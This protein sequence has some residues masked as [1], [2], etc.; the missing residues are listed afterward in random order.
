[1]AYWIPLE[2]GHLVASCSVMDDFS[3]EAYI[4]IEDV[5]TSNIIV[6]VALDSHF[7]SFTVSAPC[8][9]DCFIG[10]CLHNGDL[11]FFKLSDLLA[12]N[13]E[14]FFSTPSLRSESVV[15][16]TPYEGGRAI[17]VDQNI[18]SIWDLSKTSSME[19]T[20][21]EVTIPGTCTAISFNQNP[22]VNRIAALACVDPQSHKNL[23]CVF[24]LSKNQ[25]IMKLDLGSSA[26][27]TL[28]W[29]PEITTL[30]AVGFAGDSPSV[31]LWSMRNRTAPIAVQEL[32]YAVS[33]VAWFPQ[34]YRFIAAGDVGGNVR[35]LYTNQQ[36]LSDCGLAA[37]LE[38]NTD[39]TRVTSL[40][41]SP[42]LSGAA[43][44]GSE[45]KFYTTAC[46][47]AKNMTVIP[48]WIA[49]N[50]G[51][52]DCNVA[53]D[54]AMSVSVQG[55]VA[56]FARHWLPLSS[57]SVSD[58]DSLLRLFKESNVN[59]V[60]QLVGDS[61]VTDFLKELTKSS[62]KEALLKVF[63]FVKDAEEEVETTEDTSPMAI[64]DDAD[65]FENLSVKSVES[66]EIEQENLSTEISLEVKQEFIKFL[67]LGD[68]ESAYEL[69]VDNGF[70][71]KAS[72][73][74]MNIHGLNP[75]LRL[76]S[77]LGSDEIDDVFL[78]AFLTREF[79]VIE[80]VVDEENWQY[81]LL[82]LLE[83][84]SEPELK[85]HVVNLSNSLLS[86]NLE[87][88]LSPN[89]HDLLLIISESYDLLVRSWRERY[90]GSNMAPLLARICLL[91]LAVPSAQNDDVIRSVFDEVYEVLKRFGYEVPGKQE[92]SLPPKHHATPPLVQPQVQPLLHTQVQPPVQP[93][94]PPMHSQMQPPM[95][96]QVQ[97]PMHT[98]V[99][100][101]MMHTPVQSPPS[102]SKVV[103]AY[104]KPR[105]AMQSVD[106]SNILD[107]FRP[108]VA[109][110]IQV[111]SSWSD[112]PLPK[113]KLSRIDTAVGKVVDLLHELN[114]RNVRIDFAEKFNACVDK[115][116]EGNFAAA[117]TA[118]KTLAPSLKTPMNLVISTMKQL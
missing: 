106:V 49:C 16:I 107:N 99:Q 56:Q 93:Q 57:Q 38:S 85:E 100:P 31:Q 91:S 19:T 61:L 27:T 97:T 117:S 45:S 74:F 34:D 44:I 118:M 98:Q 39:S 66:M 1:M 86:R 108:G 46:L 43:V 102:Q 58:L 50:R 71:L 37:S 76:L 22:K 15:A 3:Q 52:S 105:D 103:E 54:D 78:R 113:Q 87:E 116:A 62:T 55:T 94:M 53:L 40:S 33:A 70:L 47:S 95:R 5:R 6:Q 109:K 32:P 48:D 96:T 59:E 68:R 101:P 83:F 11:V 8:D 63:G 88:T 29:S 111:I 75:D 84:A 28:C 13:V 36:S 26:P 41:L 4:K 35:L 79:D 80:S 25:I 73:L 110:L 104:S 14:P 42:C 112:R 23:L 12:E 18:L 7:A 89:V 82:F 69:L 2:D 77:K 90:N 114:S 65:F 60:A 10:G 115:L 9:D 72:V 92:V 30:L 64:D 24:D 17:S 21:T 67:A 20:P 51:Q 81:C